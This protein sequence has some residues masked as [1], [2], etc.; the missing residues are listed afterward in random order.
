MTAAIA[1]YVGHCRRQGTEPESRAPDDAGKADR[2]VTAGEGLGRMTGVLSADE[3]TLS[4]M[5]LPP[6]RFCML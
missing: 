1:V 3:W 5:F 4:V 6:E 2:P